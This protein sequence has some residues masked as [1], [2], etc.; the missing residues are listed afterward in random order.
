[1]MKLKMAQIDVWAAE[2]QDEPGGLSRTLRAIADSGADLDCV[3]ARRTPEHE[4]KGVVFM[5]TLNDRE[6]LDAAKQ[7]GLHRVTHLATLKI[8]GT[9]HPGIGADLTRIVADA[10][11]SLHG[12]TATVF[13]RRFVCYASFDS[14]ADMKKALGAI[15]AKFEETRL[16]WR[17]ILP[18]R[19]EKREK[20]PA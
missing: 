2:I 13:G 11:I 20:I 5:T 17:E 4:R 9:D 8:E 18:H 7:S 16:N 19:T 1:M 10:G 3:I 6:K 14:V 15:K 12:L